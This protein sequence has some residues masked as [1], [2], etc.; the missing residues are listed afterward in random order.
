MAHFARID[1]GADG[2]WHWQMRTP[3]GQ[4]FEWTSYI[5][6]ERPGEYLL[7]RTAEDAPLS[8]EGMVVFSPGPGERGTR[9][10]LAMSFRPPGGAVGAAAA[11]VL[12]VVP[13]TLAFK[14]LQRF[15]NLVETDEIATNESPSGRTSDGGHR[16]ALLASNVA[17]DRVSRGLG[18]FSIGLGLAEIAAPRQ[19]ASVAGLPDRPLLLRMLGLREI[20]SGLGILSQ[21]DR[22]PWLWSR[23]AGDAMDL[24]LLGA[25]LRSP[26]S[27]RARVG[28]ATAA[29]IAV[30]AVDALS[31]WR[32]SGLPRPSGTRRGNDP[33]D[34]SS[35]A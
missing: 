5:V 18:W 7:W 33:A 20:G 15:K 27:S 31:G 8:N 9:V 28:G 3:L 14:A 6:E 13:A 32:E 34:V 21:R 11:K 1:I 4:E 10:R 35:R 25:A 2:G 17:Q 26:K 30:T 29:V 23:V 19:L 22:A 12:N 24:A 16:H